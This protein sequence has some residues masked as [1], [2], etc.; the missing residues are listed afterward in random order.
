MPTIGSLGQLPFICS[1][2]K[3]QTFSQLSRSNKVKWAKHEVIGK[4]PV[5]EYIGEDLRTVSMTICF[6]SNFT[7]PPTEGID[8]LNRMLENKLYKTLIIGGEYLGRYVIESVEETRKHHDGKG[9]CHYAEVQISL[10][11]WGK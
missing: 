5:M 1:P 8:R 3:V 2:K 7:Q 9:V 11:E 4:K 6:D 10:T